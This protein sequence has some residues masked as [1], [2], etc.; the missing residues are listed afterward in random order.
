MGVSPSEIAVANASATRTHVLGACCTLGACDAEPWYGAR[1]AGG[2][3]AGR[4]LDLPSQCHDRP[5]HPQ[6]VVAVVDTKAEL[7]HG[8]KVGEGGERERGGEG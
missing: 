5:D 4:A 1:L 3:G 2:V 6:R 8:V 7:Y